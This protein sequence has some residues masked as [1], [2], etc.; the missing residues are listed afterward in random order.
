MTAKHCLFSTSSPTAIRYWLLLPTGC[1]T[2]WPWPLVFRHSSLVTYHTSRSQHSNNSWMTAI[3]RSRVMTISIKQQQLLLLLLLQL[4]K[5]FVKRDR[6]WYQKR[7]MCNR[8]IMSLSWLLVGIRN[9]RAFEIH[10]PVCLFTTPMG[11]DL[12][13]IWGSESQAGIRINQVW[14]SNSFIF[15][16]LSWP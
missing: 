14:P 9:G 4:V 6:S 10:D 7:S 11:V 2:L 16:P 12:T 3:I 15:H 1:M 13:K 5:Q 8:R